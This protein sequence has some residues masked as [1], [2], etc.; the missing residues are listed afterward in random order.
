MLRISY[1]KTVPLMLILLKP[2]GLFYVSTGLAFINSAFCPQRVLSLF[3]WFSEQTVTVF[4]FGIDS[5]MCNRD[6]ECLRPCTNWICK[7]KWSYHIPEILFVFCLILLN[8]FSPCC[9]IVERNFMVCFE[10]MIFSLNFR[11]G[12]KSSHIESYVILFILL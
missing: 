2:S 12:R 3:G 4:L 5:W 10:K 7:Y 9:V 8:L 11:S 1:Y 6:P